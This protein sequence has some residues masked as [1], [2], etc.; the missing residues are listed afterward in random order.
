MLANLR[1]T[2]SP[3]VLNLYGVVNSE[4]IE[5]MHDGYTTKD[6]SNYV[7]PEDLIKIMNVLLDHKQMKEE[8]KNGML[9]FL[10]EN[11]SSFSYETLAELA[12]INAAK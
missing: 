5:R 10:E 9:G 4:L 7:K 11:M 6:A 2:L 8:L 12:V 1:H 3:A